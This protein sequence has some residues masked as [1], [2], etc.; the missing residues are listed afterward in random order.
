MSF[1]ERLFGLE[2]RIALVTGS[3]SGIGRAL[4]TGLA[5]AGAHVIVNG[6]NA[7]KADAVRDQIIA[8][9]YKASVSAFDVTNRAS[10]VAAIDKIE[11]EIGPIDILFNNAGMQYRCALED[12]PEDAWRT[13]MAT[14]LDSVFFVGQAV[15][16]KMLPRKRGKIINTCSVMSELGR[17]SVSPYVATKGAVKM[18]TKAM[19]TEWGPKG[20]N[21][22]GIGPGYFK[23]ELTD[24]LVN[25]KTFTAW[26]EART[27]QGRWGDVEDLVG[28]AIYLA[29][30]AS[31]YVNGHVLY[32]DG[33]LTSSV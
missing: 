33:G 12:F 4:A 2:G 18:L 23:T 20:L 6:R 27:P 31:V 8:A 29:S 32:V 28:A 11:A 14:N 10:V 25:D 1:V 30:N 24:A 15:A 16:K 9:G 5:A 7:S 19:A 22:N 17:A 13:I 26:L 3:S 21:V